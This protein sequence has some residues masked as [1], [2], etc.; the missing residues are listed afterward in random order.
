MAEKIA[1]PRTMP[2]VAADRRLGDVHD[3]GIDDVEELHRAQ[4]E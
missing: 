1:S 2:Q 3:R 4:Q